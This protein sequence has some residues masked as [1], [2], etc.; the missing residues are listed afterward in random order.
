[1]R[2]PMIGIVPLL[3]K[4]MDSYW[5]APGYMLGIQQAGGV[6]VMLPLTDQLDEIETFIEKCDGLLLAGGPDINPKIYGEDMKKECGELC[7]ER[8]EP[9]MLALKTALKHNK[10]VLGICRGI[11]L[12]N[13]CLGGTLYQDIPTQNPSELQHV[14]DA[15]HDLPTHR[16]IL[17]KNKPLSLALKEDMIQVNSYHHQAIK[18][19]SPQLEIMGKATDGIVESVYAPDYHFVWGVQWHPELMYKEDKTSQKIFQYFVNACIDIK[20]LRKKIIEDYFQAWID[21]NQTI[22]DQVF[23]S[24]IVY[25]ECYGPEYHGIDEINQWFNDWH[26][27]GQVMRWDIKHMIYQENQVVVEWNF[28]CVYK[29]KENQFDGVSIIEFNQHHQIEKVKEF[30]SKSNHTYPYSS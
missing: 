7:E 2:K 5:M 24:N 12:L 16:V 25:S 29:E 8:D 17:E 6:P 28:Q 15:K 1:M 4:E 21:N 9:E 18:D 22:I 27:K 10:A 26:Q 14:Q 19:L 20:D 11:Q 30:Q 23:A 3:D 13:V